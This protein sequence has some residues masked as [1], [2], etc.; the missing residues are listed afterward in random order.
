MSIPHHR[1]TIAAMARVGKQVLG[2][3]NWGNAFR[4][5]ATKAATA[6]ST[7]T[8]QHWGSSHPAFYRN[9]EFDKDWENR[10]DS[11]DVNGY[12]NHSTDPWKRALGG[13]VR[14]QLTSILTSSLMSED[15]HILFTKQ[16]PVAVCRGL[17]TD[18]LV[19]WAR[20]KTAM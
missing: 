8:N 6:R 3:S 4:R 19:V 16:I 20:I 10:Y 5:S 13:Q 7:F 17:A 15:F 14:G 11:G 1:L 18:K 9:A 2:S 12:R